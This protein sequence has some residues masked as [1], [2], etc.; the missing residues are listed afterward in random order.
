MG[1]LDAAYRNED[2]LGVLWDF[3]VKSP[4]PFVEKLKYKIID[5]SIPFFKFTTERKFSGETV[6]KEIEEPAEFSITI[7]ESSDISTY[8]FFEKWMDLFY[9]SDARVFRKFASRQNYESC[10]Y[11]CDLVMYKP[12]ILAVG[13]PYVDVDF[14]KPNAVFHA[15]KCLPVGID[16][17]SFNY[18]GEPIQYTVTLLAEKI[19]KEFI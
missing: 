4:N 19:K 12:P 8:T 17:V 11:D 2:Q 1:Y 9:D 5:A 15:Y 7:R 6:I 3:E 10:K 13:L 16:P 18:S 14:S